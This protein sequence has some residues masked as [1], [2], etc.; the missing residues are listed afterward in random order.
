MGLAGWNSI[1][2]SKALPKFFLRIPLAKA[3]HLSFFAI[4]TRKKLSL[5]RP[6]P[7]DFQ[8]VK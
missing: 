3:R 7:V 2:Q 6:G 8:V 5:N 4:I 1:W